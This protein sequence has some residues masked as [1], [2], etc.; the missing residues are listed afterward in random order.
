[1]IFSFTK[2]QLKDFYNKFVKG[3]KP[4]APIRRIIEKF[5]PGILEE[6]KIYER[7]N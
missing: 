5:I 4:E 1:M 6:Q 2:S 7:E 3:I